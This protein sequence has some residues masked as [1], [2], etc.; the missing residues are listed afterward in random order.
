M[1]FQG[2]LST[3]HPA[4]ALMFLSQLSLN[5][6]LSV[7]RDE[8][9]L[10][11]T[12]KNGYLID[13]QSA[14][15]D[16]KMLQI[17]R[18]KKIV[19]SNQDAKIQQIRSETGMAVRQLLGELE[20]AT[21]SDIK[22][23]LEITINEVLLE[24]FLLEEGQFHF[25][26]T[27]VEPDAFGIKVDTNAL[28]ITVLS[29]ADECRNFEK[30]IQTLD[31]I[32]KLNGSSDQSKSLP[33][34]ER[35]L[36]HLASRKPTTVRQ[37]IR[38]APLY[39]HKTLRILEKLIENEILH[40]A[41]AQTN[42]PA[43]VPASSV[44]PLFGAFKQAF[45]MLM[46]NQEV[47]KKVEAIIGFCK[48]YY[49]I[50]LILTAKEQQIIHCKSFTIEKGQTIRQKAIKETL[51]RIDQD[52]VFQ[53]VHKTG[54]GFFGN[55]FPSPII[56]R[57]ASLP[58]KGECALLPVLNQPQLTMFFYAFSGRPH[59]GVTPHHYLELLSWLIAPAD[60]R[61]KMLSSNQTVEAPE[62]APPSSETDSQTID[63]DTPISIEQLVAKIKDLPPL[64]STA[65]KAL[66][67]LSDPNSS[68]DSVE[69][70][71]AH[72][73]ALVAKLI[74]VSNSVLYG[75]Y[76]KVISLRQALTRLGA[77]T[78]K[79]LILAA[80]TRSY[81]LKGHKGIKTYGPQLWQHSVECGLAARR[82]A[83]ACG[84]D[85]PEVAFIGGIMHDIGKLA[86][87]MIDDK[88]Y[89]E[90]QRVVLTERIMD[91][92]AEMQIVGSSHTLIGRLLMEKWHMPISVRICA[93]FHHYPEQAGKHASL[94]SIIAYANHL[95]HTLGHYP[96][97][98]TDDS[99]GAHLL[100]AIGMSPAQNEQ[101]IEIVKKDYQNTEIM[102]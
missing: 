3:Y 63:S 7:A 38:M 6:I 68:A 40:L 54:I 83:S 93:E 2:D 19:D 89:Q 80:S 56:G 81:F 66:E 48:N 76:Q 62:A 67:L 57:V 98:E 51:G 34:E 69:N 22:P 32:I 36:I 52:V 18:L 60:K 96:Q 65:A 79:S 71:I 72:D 9:L 61:D 97:S 26:D 53:A 50:I 17:L 90:I 42:T 44:D 24:L 94:A 11:L 29:H 77:K 75:G 8:Q 85:D 100:K 16:E 12:F 74:K 78:T 25:T 30:S 14:A 70:A 20:L 55:V 101:L 87:L 43:P 64:P 95:S 15:G 5:G 82:I 58:P 23:I 35:M 28:A 84:Y 27:K 59:S 102:D 39:S 92:A 33:F 91:I 4:D 1:I 46:G 49:D 45:K 10:T 31:R 41:P 47:L 73:Q 86:I 37:L 13:A 99:T 21:H 88:K